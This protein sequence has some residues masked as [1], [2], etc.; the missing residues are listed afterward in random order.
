MNNENN[1]SNNSN[2]NLENQQKQQPTQPQFL[3][4]I[5]KVCAGENFISNLRIPF[6]P[7]EIMNNQT[8]S[9]VSIPHLKGSICSRCNTYHGL[10]INLIPTRL[11]LR[12]EDGSEKIVE[13]PAIL[14]ALVPMEKPFLNEESLIQTPVLSNINKL[15]EFNKGKRGN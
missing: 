12:L 10:V 4:D 5:C 6:P 11:Q 9:I 14:F 7:V 2:N 1:N 13:A 8:S 3:T 15:L